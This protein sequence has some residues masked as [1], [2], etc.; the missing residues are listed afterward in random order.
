LPHWDLHLGVHFVLERATLRRN[1]LPGAIRVHQVWCASQMSGLSISRYGAFAGSRPHAAIT[2]QL[3]P[4]RGIQN[5]PAAVGKDDDVGLS[6][7]D[8]PGP[9]AEDTP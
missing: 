1:E 3:V 6:V 9:P 7:L 8:Q 5:E 2:R 4:R